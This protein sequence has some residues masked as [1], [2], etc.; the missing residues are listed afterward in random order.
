MALAA[1]MRMES[2]QGRGVCLL[3]PAHLIPILLITSLG[4]LDGLDLRFRERR[5]GNFYFVLL[6]TFRPDL[7][8]SFAERYQYTGLPD[9]GPFEP[10][11]IAWSPVPNASKDVP[12]IVGYDSDDEMPD[13]EVQSDPDDEAPSQLA[14][15]DDDDDLPDF[16]PDGQLPYHMRKAAGRSVSVAGP[17]VPATSK[18]EAYNYLGG[19]LFFFPG[20]TSDTGHLAMLSY[21]VACHWPMSRRGFH[22]ANHHPACKFSQ[23]QRQPDYADQRQPHPDRY[24]SESMGRTDGE[25]IE[26]AWANLNTPRPVSLWSAANGSKV[27]AKL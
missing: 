6:E 1:V 16:L 24:Q 21:D 17:V 12:H 7:D 18:G 11:M 25:A 4:A 13:L 27:R 15:A 26:R 10:K 9:M 8:P 3:A 19:G 22:A 23:L 14:G 5:I 20:L 2:Q